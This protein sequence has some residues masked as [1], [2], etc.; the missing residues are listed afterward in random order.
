MQKFGY[1]VQGN[2]FKFGVNE[3]A[4]CFFQP[5]TGR[6]SETVMV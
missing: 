2:I 3:G 4:M 6:I 5:K 1:A